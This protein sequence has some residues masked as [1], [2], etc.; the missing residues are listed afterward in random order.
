MVFIHRIG[1]FSIRSRKSDPTSRIRR[2]TKSLDRLYI[3]AEWGDIERIVSLFQLLAEWLYWAHSQGEVIRKWLWY[4]MAIDIKMIPYHGH[5]LLEYSWFNFP[6]ILASVFDTYSIWW[7]DLLISRS[8][9]TQEQYE[10]FLKHSA[11][12]SQILG[13]LS[14]PIK[15]SPASWVKTRKGNITL[16]SRSWR[17][18]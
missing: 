3:N 9:T 7:N 16:Q 11:R 15:R 1:N 2:D 18:T 5:W 4:R 6:R 17:R 12:I 14:T 8:D 13:P 10:L